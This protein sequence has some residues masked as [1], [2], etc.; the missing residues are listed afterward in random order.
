M[1]L[2]CFRLSI[3]EI[4]R[5]L[6]EDNDDELKSEDVNEII[7]FPP[8]DGNETYEDSDD[9]NTGDLNRMTADQLRSTAEVVLK[10]HV[11]EEIVRNSPV[12]KKAKKVT[13]KWK[14]EKTFQSSVISVDINRYDLPEDI[15]CVTCWESVFTDDL[16]DFLVDMSNL[17]ASQKNHVLNLTREELKVY[18]GI[19]LLTGYMTPK[20]MRMFWET[21]TDVHNELVSTA[22]RRNRF[23]EIH[24]YLHLCD[25]NNLPDNDK[26]AKVSEY[27][28][29][30]NE[31]FYQNFKKILS[32]K[33][34]IDETMV[35]YFGRHSC[36]QHIHGKPLRF[37]YKLWSACT[38]EGY[39]VQFVPYQGASGPKLQHQQE[40][41][42]GAA[43]VLDLVNKLPADTK[44][45]VYVD[46][47]FT[48]LPLLEKLTEMG[49]GGTGTIR[50]NR[51]EKCPLSGAKA[52]KKTTR[53][54]MQMRTS[55]NLV[56]VQWHDNIIV[57]MA[58]DKF[59]L[60]PVTQVNRIGFC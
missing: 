22:M 57:T 9:D 38:P 26:F 42:L 21:K 5:I 30:L 16:F 34:S 27:Y 50:E 24:K 15:D 14:E 55:S 43:V 56:I 36:K 53:G 8:D 4:A 18:V 40:L 1:V 47:F 46:N 10:N 35:P 12:R 25:S 49:H 31:S 32:N 44:Y 13:R 19:L 2:F 28:Q 29:K 58:S 60:E 11:D 39:L 37:G 52:M 54:N 7:I 48:G 41:G 33:V 23:F 45:D 6:E 59:D 51:T 20:N 3:D 17:Y